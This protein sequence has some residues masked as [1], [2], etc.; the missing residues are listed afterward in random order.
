MLGYAKIGLHAWL[1]FFFSFWLGCRP[2]FFEEKNDMSPATINNVL[3]EKN[4]FREP[5]E[6]KAKFFGSKNYFHLKI[7]NK[8]PHNLK[9]KKTIFKLKK[10]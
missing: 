8:H 5:L 6:N 10:P 4:S 7:S 3:Y 1:F 2:S 9:Q